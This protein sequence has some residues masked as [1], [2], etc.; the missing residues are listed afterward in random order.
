M[1]DVK[2]ATLPV[3][4]AITSVKLSVIFEL[5]SLVEC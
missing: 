2:V 1:I 4:A 3:T 5:V